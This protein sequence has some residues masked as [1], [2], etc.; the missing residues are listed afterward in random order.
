MDP[1]ARHVRGTP[2]AAVASFGPDA[3]GGVACR[4]FRTALQ[5]G[6]TAV[7][8]IGPGA[9]TWQQV[10]REATTRKWWYSEEKFL[11]T[12]LG[13]PIAR[14]RSLLLCLPAGGQGVKRDQPSLT[15]SELGLRLDVASPVGPLLKSCASVAPDC[16][17]APLAITMDPRARRVD[18]KLLPQI[19]GHLA[20]L[21]GGK[22]NL[23]GRGG[24]LPTPT[25][26][27]G[28]LREV[29]LSEPTG[30]GGVVRAIQLMDWRRLFGED[31]LISGASFTFQNPFNGP[32]SPNCGSA[33]FASCARRLSSYSERRR[34]S[35]PRPRPRFG[36]T[37]R[38]ATRLGRRP[39][40]QAA[41]P[42]R[43]PAYG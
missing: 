40:K 26:V 10:K 4:A 17:F 9:T 20:L 2:L 13:D 39:Q 38:L 14:N 30:P 37:P 22:A 1:S 27:K 31:Q 24:P 28:T 12:E 19:V 23:Y 5:R 41:K 36:R 42:A 34:P 15:L 32:P 43:Q 6:A 29:Y 7:L 25:L 35:G 18:Q 16:W 3:D 33:Y 8:L 21:G 11:E